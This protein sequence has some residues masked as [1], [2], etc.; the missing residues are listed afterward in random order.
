MY[1]SNIVYF[2]IC[3]VLQSEFKNLKELVITFDKSD[4]NVKYAQQYISDRYGFKI[5][6]ITDNNF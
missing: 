5:K 4:P 6:F 1:I 2:E 3:R